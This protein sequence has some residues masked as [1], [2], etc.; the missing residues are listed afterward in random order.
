MNWPVEATPEEQ[1][2]ILAAE[3]DDLKADLEQA[4][5]II[6]ELKAQL[7]GQVDEQ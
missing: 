3:L 1:I 5:A 2:E 6:K 7:N 4:D